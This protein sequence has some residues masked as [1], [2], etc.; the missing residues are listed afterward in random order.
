MRERAETASARVAGTLAQPAEMTNVVAIRNKT[1]AFMLFTAASFNLIEVLPH[2]TP[3]P[4]KLA[5]IKS[6]FSS[7]LLPPSRTA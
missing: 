7:Q 3:R 6:Q 4:R 2:G 1:K 5:R